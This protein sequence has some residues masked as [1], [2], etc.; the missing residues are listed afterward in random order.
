MKEKSAVKKVQ[1]S[2]IIESYYKLRIIP[3]I[4]EITIDIM[5]Y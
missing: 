4:Y 1:N 2:V 3:F 5:S